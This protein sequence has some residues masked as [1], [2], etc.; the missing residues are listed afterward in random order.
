MLWDTVVEEATPNAKGMLGALHIKNV[1]SG[2]RRELPVNGLFFAIGHEPASAFLD[3]QVTDT[4]QGTPL[5]STS[6][7]SSFRQPVSVSVSSRALV[8]QP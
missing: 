8:R 6:C 4:Y 7:S 2:E 1:K 3:G 5:R